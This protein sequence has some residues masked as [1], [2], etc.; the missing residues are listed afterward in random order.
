MKTYA[1]NVVVVVYYE[2]WMYQLHYPTFKMNNL[3]WA[4]C[5]G[6]EGSS[7]I[8]ESRPEEGSQAAVWRVAVHFQWQ[9]AD[10]DPG[11]EC[12]RCQ[13]APTGHLFGVRNPARITLL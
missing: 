12:S 2:C 9:C 7:V 4:F 11:C 8:L 3:Q 5:T 10:A 6:F 1:L 13:G